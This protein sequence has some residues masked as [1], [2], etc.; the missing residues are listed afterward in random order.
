VKQ[1]DNE[2]KGGDATATG[3]DGGDADTGNEQKFNGNAFAFSK[4]VGEPRDPCS[5]KGKGRHDGGK[6]EAEA[7]GGDTT[8]RSGDAT[9]GDG[10]D[11]RASAGD[12][13]ALNDA[14]VVQRNVSDVEEGTR[15]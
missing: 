8:A 11:A 10:G 1:G 12:A 4:T 5:C 15:H 6:S 2:A 9:G 13:Q 3:G 14:W 7:E